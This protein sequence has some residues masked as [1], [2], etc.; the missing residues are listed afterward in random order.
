MT[1]SILEVRGIAK[2]FGDV[3]AVHPLSFEVRPG[4]I[5]GFLGPNGAGKTTTLRMI[6]G[7][8]APDAGELRFEGRDRV[9]RSRVGYLPEERGLFEDAPVLDTVV[10]LG[11]LRGLSRADAR[12]AALPL[13]ERLELGGR[14]QDKVSALSKGNQQKV[15]LVGAVLHAPALAVLDEPF[16]GL[17]PVNQELFVS[18]MRELRDRG[19]AVLLS[20]HHLDLVERLA[21]R[22]LLIASG[23]E[24][25]AGTLEQIR[26]EAAGGIDD[27]VQ[28]H[29]APRDGLPFAAE[30]LRAR[31]ASLL[32]GGRAELRDVAPESARLDLWLPAGTDLGPLLTAAAEG[33]RLRRVETRRLP[34]HE[35][36]L[37][38][39]RAT[40]AR[41]SEEEVT[42]GA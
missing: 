23:R 40:G 24:V 41:V 17:D 7:I 38:A 13:L 26:R 2:R 29:L 3:Q 15:Q 4:E 8:T 31:L 35:I 30:P 1:P 9:D 27:I 39:V 14:L 36:Y 21:D 6:L 22:F 5:F 33:A 32:E 19:A 42:R 16:A 37:Q 20:A 10:Y 28:L 18:L 12:A 25:L 34:L 11:E